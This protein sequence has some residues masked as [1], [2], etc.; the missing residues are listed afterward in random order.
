MKIIVMTM[1]LFT[2]AVVTAQA[3]KEKPCIAFV[4]ADDNDPYV[5]RA[6]DPLRTA[7]TFSGDLDFYPAYKASC[8]RVHVIAAAIKHENGSHSGFVVCYIITDP[9]Q[10]FVDQGLHIGRNEEVFEDAMRKAAAK[11]IKHIREMHSQE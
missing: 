10:I 5:Q 1:L 9:A 3:E 11:T 2:C 7:V 8:W 6:R 4:A